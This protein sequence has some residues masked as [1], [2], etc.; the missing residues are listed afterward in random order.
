MS[1]DISVDSGGFSPLT[2]KAF[3]SFCLLGKIENRAQIVLGDC[4]GCYGKRIQVRGLLQGDISRKRRNTQGKKTGKRTCHF[5]STF[6]LEAGTML[7]T[8][9]C[10]TKWNMCTNWG[11]KREL[12]MRAIRQSSSKNPHNKALHLLTTAL[13]VWQVR[14]YNDNR[15]LASKPLKLKWVEEREKNF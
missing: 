9:W 4:S 13:S 8:R 14:P 7:L 5:N 11:V 2:L 10:K 3:P 6:P 1:G 12:V 15:S